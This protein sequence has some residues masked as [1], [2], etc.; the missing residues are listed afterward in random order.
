MIGFLFLTQDL[1]Y[2][3]SLSAA[4]PQTMAYKI[5]ASLGRIESSYR[6]TS[7]KTIVFVQD[8]HDSIQAQMNIARIIR[9]AVT[10]HGVKT[11]FEEGYE[12]MVPTDEV[13]KSLTE[14]RT[15]E[16]VSYYLLDHLRIGGAEFAHINRFNAVTRHPSLV[17]RKKDNSPR[18]TSDERQ[19][20]ALIGA[21]SLKGHF[22]NVRWFRRAVKE[23][24]PALQDIDWLSAEFQRLADGKFSKPAKTYLKLKQSFDSEQ[25]DLPHYLQRARPLASKEASYPC[26][27][28]L[29]KADQVN[30][31]AMREQIKNMAVQV[32]FEELQRMDHDI[33]NR[34]ISNVMPS[35]NLSL[36]GGAREPDE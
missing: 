32:L 12:G 28:L 26:I 5:P 22:E 24:A 10:Q 2:G 13:Y 25:I 33:V 4:L 11:V 21:D 8:A 35:E 20:F 31:P 9:H 7:D 1:L 15:R 36:R 17:A 16:A 6:G 29:L 18:I 23:K 19:D 27:D 34:L 30:R 14:P 3:A